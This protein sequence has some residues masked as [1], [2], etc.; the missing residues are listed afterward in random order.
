MWEMSLKISLPQNVKLPKLPMEITSH[1]KGWILKHK[2]RREIM[3]TKCNSSLD[4][5]LTNLF[6]ATLLE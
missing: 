1:R 3:D 2:G 6:Q 4:T 5:V